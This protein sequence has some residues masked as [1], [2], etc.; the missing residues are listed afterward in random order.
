MDKIFIRSNLIY[1]PLL[2]T[3]E[4]YKIKIHTVNLKKKG[5]MTDS[6]AGQKHQ[7]AASDG[8]EDW[9]FYI[10]DVIH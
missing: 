3:K 8:V 6:S 4:K 1:Q 9:L 10:Y 2:A 5:L 7:R